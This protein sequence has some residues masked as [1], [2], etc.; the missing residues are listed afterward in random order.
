MAD[1]SNIPHTGVFY[2]YTWAILF[3]SSHAVGAMK[4]LNEFLPSINFPVH[5]IKYLPELPDLIPHIIGSVIAALFAFLA[6][7]FY[8]FIWNKYFN[9]EKSNAK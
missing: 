9:N 2:W 5:G 3:I 7:K 4:W 6:S 1:Y 8:N